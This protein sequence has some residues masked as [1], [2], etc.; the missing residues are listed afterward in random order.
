MLRDTHLDCCVLLDEDFD[1]YPDA[2]NQLGTMPVYCYE[3][4]VTKAAA[5]LSGS[6]GLCGVEAEMLKHWLLQ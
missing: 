6:A 1:A 5:R 4:C 3:E 2:A